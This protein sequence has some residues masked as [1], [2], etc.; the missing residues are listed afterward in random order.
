MIRPDE[1]DPGKG[2]IGRVNDL[3]PLLADEIEHFGHLEHRRAFATKRAKTSTL[4]IEQKN[5]RP[6]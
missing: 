1:P 4:A 3:L 5:D 2:R 6:R